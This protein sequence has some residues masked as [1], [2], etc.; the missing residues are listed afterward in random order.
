MAEAILERGLAARGIDAEVHSAGRLRGGSPTTAEGLAA[1]RQLGVDISGHRSR[2]V[3]AKMLHRADLVLG[4]AREHIVHAVTLA[5]EALPRA[6][7]LKDLVRRAG[8]AGPRPAQQ[9]LREWLAG[10]AASRAPTDL[11]GSSPDDDIAD[12][13]GQSAARYQATAYEIDGL[14][15][16]LITLAWPDRAR[17]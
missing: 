11:L 12:P 1:M 10:L 6:F 9:P 2:R 7:T 15:D 4:M 16:R 8:A 14:I 17:D 5:P 3:T 13:I